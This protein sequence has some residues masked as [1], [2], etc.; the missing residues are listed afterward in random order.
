MMCPEQKY[1]ISRASESI[2]LTLGVFLCAIQ[3]A[4]VLSAEADHASHEDSAAWVEQE[5]PST[6]AVAALPDGSQEKRPSCI[7]IGTAQPVEY[8]LYDERS[9]KM[10]RGLGYPAL[11]SGTLTFPDTQDHDRWSDPTRPLHVQRGEL[12]ATIADPDLDAQLA[13]ERGRLAPLWS[14][15][16]SMLR[17][18]AKNPEAMSDL[19]LLIHEGEAIQLEAAIVENEMERTLMRTVVAPADAEIIEGTRHSVNINPLSGDLFRYYPLSHVRFQVRLPLVAWGPDWT[20]DLCVDGQSAQILSIY[21]VDFDETNEEWILGIEFKPAR[22]FQRMSEKFIYRLTSTSP[23][24]Q[25]L[26][27]GL[28]LHPPSCALVG[29]RRTYPSTAPKV[30]GLLFFS[31]EE[32]SWINQDETIGGVTL[33]GM[34]ELLEKVNQYRLRTERFLEEV[35]TK[36]IPAEIMAA[37]DQRLILLRQYHAEAG[38]F[39]ERASAMTIE[40]KESGLLVGTLDYQGPL[41]SRNANLS[42]RVKSPFVE[43]FDVLVG[44]DIDVRDGDIVFVELPSGTEKLAKVF[45]VVTETVGSIQDL[46]ECKMISVLVSSAQFHLGEKAAGHFPDPLA[47]SQESGMPV[48]VSIPA[49]SNEAERTRIQ[50]Q[51]QTDFEDASRRPS[52]DRPL[53][54]IRFTFRNSSLSPLEKMAYMRRATSASEYNPGAAPSYLDLLTEAIIRDQNPETRWLAFRKLVDARYTTGFDP[55]VQIALRAQSGVASASLFHLSKRRR[56]FELFDILVQFQQQRK[57]WDTRTRREKEPLLSLT[58]QL[59]RGLIDHPDPQSDVLTHLITRGR[60]DPVFQRRAEDFFFSVIRTEGVNAPAS[61][62]ILRGEDRSG[63][64]FW[65]E[66]ALQAAAVR[67]QA[68]GDFYVSQVFQRELARRELLGLS[69]NSKYGYGANFIET[70]FLYLRDMDKIDALARSRE[71]YLHDLHF[72]ESS[73]YWATIFPLDP[74]ILAVPRER[75]IWPQPVPSLESADASTAEFSSFGQDVEFPAFRHLTNSERSLLIKDLGLK[76]DYVTLVLLLC[77]PFVRAHNAGDI[78]DWLL[79]TPEARLELARYYPQSTDADLLDLIDERQFAVEALSDIN[80]TIR[81]TEKALLTADDSLNSPAS[82][83]ASPA[84]IHIYQQLLLRLWDRSQLE[85][86]RFSY[87]VT[88]AGLLPSGFELSDDLAPLYKP[89]EERGVA[90]KDLKSAIRY[91]R[92]RRALNY[93]VERERAKR[94]ENRNVEI[95][96]GPEEAL[97]RQVSQEVEAGMPPLCHPIA[98]LEERLGVDGAGA[99]SEGAS[100][101]LHDTIHLV[102]IRDQEFAT[103]KRERLRFEDITAYAVRIVLAP[104]YILAIIPLIWVANV[105]LLLLDCLR[106]RTSFSSDYFRGHIRRAEQLLDSIDDME[107][108]KKEILRWIRVLESDGLNVDRLVRLQ[109]RVKRIMNHE[110]LVYHVTAGAELDHRQAGQGQ[111][112]ARPDS[113]HPE[114]A[115]KLA[116]CLTV[117]ALLCRLTAE[118]IWQEAGQDSTDKHRMYLMVEWFLQRSSYFSGYRYTLNPLANHQIA[119][120]YIWQDLPLVQAREQSVVLQGVLI[121]LNLLIRSVNGFGRIFLSL[122]MRFLY[123]F[124]PISYLGA[125]V[126]QISLRRFVIDRGN[127]L[128]EKLYPDPV[129]LVEMTRQRLRTVWARNAF[130]PDQPGGR[131]IFS[132]RRVATRV[133]PFVVVTTIVS[134]GF[135]YLYELLTGDGGVSAWNIRSTGIYAAFAALVIL[136]FTMVLHWLPLLM[137]W[138]PFAHLRN[139]NKIRLQ[140]RRAR[141]TLLI[142]SERRTSGRIN[143]KEELQKLNFDDAVSALFAERDSGAPILDVLI[144]MVENPDLLN[145]Y[146]RLAKTLV[147]PLT[148]VLAYPTSESMDGGGARLATLKT[149]HE[150]YADI[151]ARY[152]HLPDRFDQTRSVF[153]PIG[154]DCDPL[155]EFP[156]KI[157]APAGSRPVATVAL[158]P[159]LLAMANAQSLLRRSFVYQERGTTN[160]FVGSVT[161]SPQR[162]Y[163]GPHNVDQGG[164]FRGGITLLGAFESIQTAGRQG[165]L[166]IMGNRAFI[167]NSPDQLRDIIQ[168][169]PE[170][171]HWLDPSNDEK[172]QLPVAQVVIERF[173]TFQRYERHIHTCVRYIN[174]IQRIREELLDKGRQGER[175]VDNEQFL[176]GVA[177]HYMRH[178]IVPWFI[179]YQGGSLEN[180]RSGVLTGELGVRDRRRV[181]HQRVL[182]LIELIQEEGQATRRQLPKV[183]FVNAPSARVH[184]A[185]T[186]QDAAAAWINLMALFPQ[187]PAELDT[188]PR[189]RVPDSAPEHREVEAVV[190]FD[191][192]NLRD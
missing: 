99:V 188:A 70:G 133:L 174:E 172:R 156:V 168:S 19:L 17:M 98:F 12:I 146:H 191:A 154:R 71:N 58:Y 143:V 123:L 182:E 115:M 23:V 77:D 2:I 54:P 36:L 149:I 164:K 59:L 83:A 88:W 26:S 134:G 84:S 132:F 179:A 161:I 74:E 119:K 82:R 157:A 137:G 30:S 61:V 29:Q 101:A 114:T 158:T 63:H 167:R 173:R 108:V 185:K 110:D 72:L 92:E 52:L 87:L 138:I 129:A 46:R 40:A 39:V 121:P 14:E 42:A 127:A 33:T 15:Y 89:L 140:R 91:V 178:L 165:A 175:D 104:L 97:L 107:A 7:F 187:A 189:T 81:R 56:E 124:T 53:Y 27:E 65:S 192:A 170:L 95:H 159:F 41:T 75:G 166:V 16:E 160:R 155:I 113:L 120:T 57:T 62:R 117:L 5:K 100:L 180:Y 51:L 11:S 31:K 35:E 142:E 8:D 64:P 1:G 122:P 112:I 118:K 136:T 162:L 18:K 68:G 90:E 186:E 125:V 78:L 45:T 169:H 131:Y 86:I 43:V 38:R 9:K 73:P 177:I 44:R 48:Y 32:N 145:R 147:S 93:A 141:R 181:F 49:Y 128:E 171:Q 34:T 69:A 28:T 3:A 148:A 153:V 103:G 116:P 176:N 102:R 184:Y 13:A 10:E 96:P 151:R 106:F 144:L 20:L 25:R 111:A 47:A 22:S 190:T 152:P 150:Q 139:L 37:N 126:F 4:P 163:V 105:T 183:R 76:P 94:A 130:Q 55:F 80:A 135:P 6:A 60:L 66:R 24:I 67:A 85:Q 109:E 21:S 50:S 79:L